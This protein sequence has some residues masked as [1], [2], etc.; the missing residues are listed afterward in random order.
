[1]IPPH[2]QPYAEIIEADMQRQDTF[3]LFSS[4][5]FPF[6]RHLDELTGMGISG[7]VVDGEFYS[8]FGSR[9]YR[10]LKTHM[11][12]KVETKVETKKETSP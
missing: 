5:P 7:A 6:A 8:W 12:T 10:M 3:Y 2:E 9:S 1:M 11:E 4:E